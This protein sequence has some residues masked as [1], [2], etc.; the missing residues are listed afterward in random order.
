MAQLLGSS[1]SMGSLTGRNRNTELVRNSAHVEHAHVVNSHFSDSGLF[2]LTVQGA[3]SHSKD[4]MGSLLE[5][6]NSLKESISDEDLQ[7]AKNQLKFNILN[8][9]ETPGSRLEEIARNYHAFNGELNFH[10]Y[11]DKI[12]SVTANDINTVSSLT[13]IGR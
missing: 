12:D 7:R 6:L 8:E 2:G 3:G 1:D 10:R 9:M 5:Q 4:L 11:A 13:S